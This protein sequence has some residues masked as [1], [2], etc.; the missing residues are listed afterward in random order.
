MLKKLKVKNFRSLKDFEIEFGKFN[1]LI[2]ENGCGK[3]NVFD[4][5]N[6]L[7]DAIES[8]LYNA[9]EKRKIFEGYGDIVY[10]HDDRNIITIEA[11]AEIEGKN[12]K[13]YVSFS[14]KYGIVK[15]ED[16]L[17]KVDEHNIKTQPYEGII[18][19]DIGKYEVSDEIKEY[20]GVLAAFKKY[21]ASITQYDFNIRQIKRNSYSVFEEYTVKE[22][23]WNIVRVL[24][25]LHA[26]YGEI[27]NEISENFTDIYPSHN[28]VIIPKQA[29][30]YIGIS[31]KI[32]ENEITIP[33]MNV[34][35]GMIKTVCLLTVMSTAKF[36]RKEHDVDVPLFLFEEIENSLYPKTIWKILELMKAGDSQIILTTHS[37]YFLNHLEPED[38]IIIKKGENGTE[39]AGNPKKIKEMIDKYQYKIGDLWA[40]EELEF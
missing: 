12:V 5:I 22:D 35:D 37:P 14:G 21:I 25:T 38:V 20:R 17:I 3:T 26:A 27:Y 19:P 15:V 39:T 34:S 30:R 40:L 16:V 33:S 32:K 28:I 2:G 4:C 8:N 23:G 13:Y 11:E 18:Y 10:A 31:E 6:F 29:M 7:H 24:D 1:V 36:F 9:V